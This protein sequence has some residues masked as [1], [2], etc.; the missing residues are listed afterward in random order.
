MASQ[1]PA[2]RYDVTTL[3][4]LEL[5]LKHV[6]EVLEAHM[7][8]SRWWREGHHELRGRRLK[9]LSLGKPH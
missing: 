6:W 7:A 3:V 2:E 1:Y 5:A 4:A 8:P 9:T